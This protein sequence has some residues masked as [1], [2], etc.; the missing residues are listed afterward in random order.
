MKY[1][2]FIVAASFFV[3]A[4][5][6]ARAPLVA[7]EVDI[8]QPMPGMQM[9]AGYL[10]LTNNS[11]ESITISHVSSPQFEAVELHETIVENEISRMVRLTAVTIEPASSVAFEPGGKHLMLMRRVGEADTVRLDFHSGETV[12]L[13]VNFTPAD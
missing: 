3:T 12:V 11:D 9:S 13:T 1:L 4:C 2:I 7:S 8:R 10:T 5:S 6:D